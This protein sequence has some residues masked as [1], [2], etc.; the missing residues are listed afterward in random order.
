MI[1]V[2]RGLCTSITFALASVSAYADISS[3]GKTSDLPGYRHYDF[4]FF[5]P[6]IILLAIGGFIGYYWLKDLYQK[7]KETFKKIFATIFI[8]CYGA[9]I[10]FIVW[11]VV[12]K[13]SFFSRNKKTQEPQQREIVEQLTSAEQ[14][15]A[16][17]PSISNTSNNDPWA[18]YP[19]VI[20][21]NNE[22]MKPND[23]LVAV[24]NNPSYSIY[25]L[26]KVAGLNIH[27]TQF[28]PFDRYCRSNFI[29]E[30]YTPGSFRDVYNRIERGWRIFNDLSNVNIEDEEISKYMFEYDTW[31]VTAPRI[32]QARNPQVIKNLKKKPL[33]D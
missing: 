24:I 13:A 29:R 22:N 26:M 19:P 20:R 5:I 27:N 23:F 12:G 7:H 17:H 31:D 8:F 6:L 15:A 11:W 2:R 1:T 33:Y 10:L 18:S 3:L 30:R 32:E 28:L 9:V 14:K 25:D 4:E 16:S 21:G